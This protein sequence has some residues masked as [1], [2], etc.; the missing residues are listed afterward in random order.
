MTVRRLRRELT[1]AEFE[2]WRARERAINTLVRHAD[3]KAAM[4]TVLRG[5]R[6]RGMGR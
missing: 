1:P 6:R 2:A 4:A 5:G 3:N